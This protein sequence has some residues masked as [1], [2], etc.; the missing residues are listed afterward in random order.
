MDKLIYKGSTIEECIEKA[1]K[2]LNI[3]AD[4]LEYD[5]IEEKKSI[6]RKNVEISVKQEKKVEKSEKDGSVQIK[7]GQIIVKDPVDGGKPSSI[8]SLRGVKL[9]VDGKEVNSRIDVYSSSQIQVILNEDEDAVREL[10]L[11]LDKDNMKAFISIKYTHKNIYALKDKQEASSVDLEAFIKEKQS[12]PV[13]TLEEIKQQ[14]SNNNIVYGIIEENLQKCLDVEGVSHLLIAQGTK[15]VDEENDSIEFKFQT[16]DTKRFAEDINGRI[17]FKSIG[18]VFALKKDDILAIRHRGKQGVE[19]K[20]I[21]GTVLK[22][23]SG[24]KLELRIGEGC[25]VDGDNVVATKDGKPAFKNGRFSVDEFHE[26]NSDVD[27]KTGNIKFMGDI[28]INGTVKEGMKIESGGSVKIKKDVD[29]ADVVAKGDIEVDGNTIGSNVTA[30]GEDVIANNILDDLTNLKENINELIKAVQQIKKY[31][32]LGQDLK[33]GQIIKVLI[34]TKFKQI[35][36]FC[37]NL[38]CNF[39]LMNSAFDQ[40]K[41]YLR[42]VLKEKF[43]GLGPL[44]FNTY[45]ELS[46]IIEEIDKKI[47]E[48]KEKISL[49]VTLV[50]EYCQDSEIN[51][52]GDVIIKGKGEYVSNIAANNKVEFLANHSIARGG[53]I[54][55]KDEIRC[56]VVGSSGGVSTK[57]IVGDKGHIW[58]Q[59]AYEN[60]VFIVGTREYNLEYPSKN[61]HAYLD[62]KG[63]LIVDKLML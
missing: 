30:G 9:L 8:N 35:T 55:A 3:S 33:D 46:D 22:Y 15:P 31:N 57:L 51:S 61:I 29:G 27:L 11:N 36:K 53:V 4:E 18:Y 17:D 38:L 62:E 39:N 21:D 52:S 23:K 14:L 19:G 6:F 48:I 25:I 59:Q 56:G 32:L 1:S 37:L 41:W 28:I 24:K 10:S 16:A 45:G 44:K 5:I 12:P 20:D 34:E 40:N 58:A 13:Y 7:D 2:D 54:K 47:A 49:P 50:I 60:T 63:D 26:V 43:I 42:N